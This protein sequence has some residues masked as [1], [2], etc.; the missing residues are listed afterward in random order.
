MQRHTDTLL[1]EQAYKAT[2]LKEHFP[3][4]SLGQVRLVIENA[5]PTELEVIEELLGGLRNVARGAK[6]G[7]QRAGRAAKERVQGAVQGAGQAVGDA[8]RGASDA[9]RAGA[10]AAGAAAGQ[11]GK[12]VK[13]MYKTGEDQAAA[14]KRKMQLINH[15]SQLE[16]LLAAHIEASPRSGL[17]AD[18]IGNYTITKLK[19]S[20]GTTEGMKKRAAT[21]ARQNVGGGVTGAAQKQYEKKKKE[22]ADQRAAGAGGVEGAPAPA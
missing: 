6:E 8:V 15:I 9:V 2:Q 7:L 10:S 4:M 20:F 18:Q 12:N 13:D 1:L 11:F 16:E 19:R 14:K 21:D 5:S 17:K 22:L 3:N